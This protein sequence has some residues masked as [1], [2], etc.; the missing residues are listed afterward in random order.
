MTSLDLQKKREKHHQIFSCNHCDFVCS[1]ISDWSRHLITLKHL[2]TSQD[3][4]TKEITPLFECVCGK[5]YKHRQSLYKHKK[6]CD[7][8]YEKE[9][10]KKENDE[11]DICISKKE[12]SNE[13]VVELIKEN[14]ELR[15][16]LIEQN[17]KII[18]I[19]KEG[20]HI[21]NHTTNNFN[22]NFFLNEQC[23]DA[24]NLM[25]FVSSLQ[26]QLKD[27]EDTG[28]IGYV[29][30]ISKIFIRGIKELDIY[31]RPIHC[32]DLKRE[33]LYI[34]DQDIWEKEDK[35]KTRIKKAI[36]FIGSKNIQQ[37]PVWVEKNPQ[38]KN[39]DS[40]KNDEYMELIVNAMIGSTPE[41]QLDNINK[42]IKN[43]SKEVF[44]DKTI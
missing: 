31:K 9:N 18:E 7:K 2:N 23:K 13:T 20:K 10:D 33:T 34:K 37:I 27:L 8:E 25:D 22:I 26:L 6:E 12:I 16:M 29:E 44:I 24:L 40:K 38:C 30:G 42:V 15:Q 4:C 21:T 3:F 28:K 39:S 17:T 36:K 19:A 5:K 43:V 35:D 1:K 41:E 11:K 32:S 14:K